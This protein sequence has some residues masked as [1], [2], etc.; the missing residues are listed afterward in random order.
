MLKFKRAVT[1]NWDV[2]IEKT[3]Q[4]EQPSVGRAEHRPRSETAGWQKRVAHGK[5]GDDW[6]IGPLGSG[7]KQSNIKEW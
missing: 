6:R 4:S 3:M 5:R 1:R 7:W 2:E